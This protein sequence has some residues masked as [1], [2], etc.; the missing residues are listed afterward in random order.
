[1]A[2]KSFID[3]GGT[4]AEYEILKA[5][6]STGRKEPQDF[7]FRPPALPGLSFFVESPRVGIRVGFSDAAQRLLD[8]S[9]GLRAPRVEVI[10]ERDALSDGKGALRAAIGG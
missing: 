5:L 1:M 9:R 7:T 6:Y 3:R 4:E 10:S 8:I 2:S